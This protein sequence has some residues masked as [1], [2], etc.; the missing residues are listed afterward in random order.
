[1]VFPGVVEERI[2]AGPRHLHQDLVRGNARQLLLLFSSSLHL[3]ST[4]ITKSTENE[5]PATATSLACDCR[6]AV[7]GR[8]VR[9]HLRMRTPEAAGTHRADGAATR[10]DRAASRG[11][12]EDSFRRQQLGSGR[13]QPGRMGRQQRGRQ[14]PGR[15]ALMF[16]SIS[17]CRLGREPGR[18]RQSGR[19]G[20]R[21]SE[22]ESGRQP[23]RSLLFFSSCLPLQAL[24]GRLST[25][26]RSSSRREDRTRPPSSP[27]RK[28]CVVSP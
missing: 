27:G 25:T 24:S 19:P 13:K 10:E 2:A 4:A 23:G 21:V 5:S 26:S 18:R 20:R 15:P 9:G 14:Q 1:M 7:T 12:L 6:I 8:E 22:S 11:R 17:T 16:S 28:P 3:P